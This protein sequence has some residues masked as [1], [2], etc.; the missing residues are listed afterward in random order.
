M[1]GSGVSVLSRLR[2]IL[3]DVLVLELADVRPETRLLE[4]MDADSITLIELAFS[5]EKELGVR[6]PEVKADEETLN[7]P[8][9][10]CARPGHAPRSDRRDRGEQLFRRQTVATMARA[11]QAEIPE[12]LEPAAPIASMRLRDLFR[13][14]TVGA[15][16]EYVAHLMDTQAHA[17]E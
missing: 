11:A 6:L 8:L 5:I 4:D 9:P 2:A 1:I 3:S 7:L 13:F 16:A 10:A 12:G 17:P 14:L 15:M